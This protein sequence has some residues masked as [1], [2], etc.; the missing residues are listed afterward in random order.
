M[1]GILFLGV[2]DPK[3]SKAIQEAADC[4]LNGE[5]LDQCDRSAGRFEWLDPENR[6]FINLFCSETAIILN[7]LKNQLVMKSFIK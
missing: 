6:V 7:N 5:L 1:F 4:I 3:I 2:L